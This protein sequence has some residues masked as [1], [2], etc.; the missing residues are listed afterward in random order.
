MVVSYK[1]VS[2][3]DKKNTTAE[4]RDIGEASIPVDLYKRKTVVRRQKRRKGD[5]PKSGEWL[6]KVADAY[7]TEMSDEDADQKVSKWNCLLVTRGSSR[8]WNNNIWRT[9][10]ENTRL[11]AGANYAQNRSLE[12]QAILRYN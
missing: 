9:F 3:F 10:I 11:L 5:K 6:A 7:E 8:G 2:P 1:V 12:F 4:K